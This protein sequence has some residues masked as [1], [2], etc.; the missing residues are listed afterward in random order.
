[1]GGMF[2]FTAP[3]REVYGLGL[4]VMLL[5]NLAGGAA[6]VVARASGPETPSAPAGA[7]GPGVVEKPLAGP[8]GASPV[9]A[10]TDRAPSSAGSS[11]CGTGTATARA[12][13]DQTGTG[14]VLRATVVND[15]NRTVELDRLAVR[16]VY[17]E[18]ARTYS[19]AASGH[20]VSPGGAETDFALPDSAWPVRPVS[21]AVTDFAFHTAGRP[22][23][24]AR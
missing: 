10:A 1:M 24:A 16:A 22:G 21:F 23:C 3:R 13:L 6:V 7:T 18:G 11:D 9:T 19:A 20:W 12:V 15:S 8:S 17:A 14:Y 4:G 5:A 2:G